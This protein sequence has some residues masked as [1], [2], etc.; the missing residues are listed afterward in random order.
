MGG[1][2]KGATPI[3][4]STDLGS[5]STLATVDTYRLNV[6]DWSINT[7]FAIN[8]DTVKN[9]SIAGAGT[10]LLVDNSASLLS[11]NYFTVQD[12]SISAGELEVL[13]GGYLSMR[14]M[15]DFIQSGG[16]VTAVGGPGTSSKGLYVTGMY[17]LSGGRLI[18]R[19]QSGTPANNNY[20]VEMYGGLTQ[21]GGAALSK[22]TAGAPA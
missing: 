16:T 21:T 18:A 9:L 19:A 4:N 3:N 17:R 1:Q 20:A 7:S 10:K 2:G 12:F 14:T 13:G 5:S 6:G 15:G 8:V 11:N 22:R